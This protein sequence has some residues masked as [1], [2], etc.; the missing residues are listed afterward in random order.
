MS[1]KLHIGI[2]E[3]SDEIT[4]R[5]LRGIRDELNPVFPKLVPKIVSRTKVLLFNSITSQPEYESIRSGE[6]RFHLGLP[7]GGDRLIDII[8]IWINSVEAEFKKFRISSAT[9]LTGGI[10]L[11]AVRS[12]YEDVISSNSA[13]FITEKGEELH[14]LQWLL[15]EGSNT[16]ISDY[17]IQL[18]PNLGRTGG[19]IMVTGA[20]WS[21]PGGFTGTPNNNFITRAIANVELDLI[22]DIRQIMEEAL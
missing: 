17:K 2:K 12:D 10:T 22:Q 9:G 11:I 6:L 20:G 16:I 1:I 5:I 18:G 4:K 13:V 15:N 21:I 8:E 14:W 7:N 3:S 19:A